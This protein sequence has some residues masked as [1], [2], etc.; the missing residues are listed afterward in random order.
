VPAI[1]AE[2]VDPGAAPL[3]HYLGVLGM[4]GMTAYFALLDIGRPKPGD[5]VLISAA[6]G[7]VG[8]AA[9]QIAK[10]KGCRVI[11]TVG[12][13]DKLAYV[14]E[15]L[16][17]DAAIDYRGKDMPALAAEIAALAPHGIDVFFDNV[18]GVL[19]DAA[20]QN[21]ALHARV[22]IC[23]MISIY[24][25]IEAPDIGIRWMRQLLIKRAL[26]QGFLVSDYR[27]RTGEFRAAVSDWLRAG[28]I[29][30]REDIVDGIAAAPR[31]FIGLLAGAN[32]GKQLVR[33]AT[34]NPA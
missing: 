21:L 13:A 1:E 9:A 11:G 2:R 31:A 15:T 12:T 30:Y 10:L 16:G 7:A 26:M 34:R 24:D 22:I 27:E 20:M 17:L 19:H 18:G 25:R 32:R 28:K 5:T 14:K 3:S 4:P 33:V 29:A 8:Q 6:A 23:G